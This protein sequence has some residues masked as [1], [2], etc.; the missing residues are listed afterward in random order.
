MSSLLERLSGSPA[1]NSQATKLTLVAAAASFTTAA[2]ILG[3]QGS[4]KKRRVRQLKD[5]LRK[6]IPPPPTYDQGSESFATG[7]YTSPIVLPGTGASPATVID[8]RGAIQPGGALEMDEELVKEQLARNI[9]FLGEEGVEKLRN[10]FVIIVGAGGV[11]S[12]AASMLVRSGV[13]KIRL[14][15]FDQVSLSSLNRHATAVQADVGTPK[16]TAMKKAFR[17][18]APWVE[19]DARVELFQE[20]AAEELLSGNPDYVIDAIDNINTKLALLKFCYDHKIPVISSMGAGAKADPSRVQISDISETFEDPLARA[21]RRKIKKMGV[22][23]GIEVV[24]STEKPHHVKLLP[25]D[26]TQAQEAD[27]YSAL[28][29]FRSRILPVLGPLPAMFGMAMATFITCKIADWPMEPVPI[30]LREALYLRV[31]RELRV[32]EQRLDTN[33]PKVETIALD[34]RDVGYV[35]EE[36]FRGKSVVSKSMDKIGLCRWKRAEPLSLQ[37][38]VVLTKSE[39]DKHVKLP[40]DADLAEVYG[41]EVVDYVEE[42]FR[43]EAEISRLR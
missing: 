10:S 4:Q 30:K 38:V 34:R 3:V 35:I 19:V 41:Q 28:P 26:E 22:D 32:R 37:N 39:M 33:V 20:D 40:L 8:A 7:E 36:I 27:E 42:R 11:G 16:V 14:I 23:T 1:F 17:S 6:S 43:E 24:Y 15:D 31:H 9:A 12:W 25:L 13:G 18:I 21:V 29:D 5:D 2:L